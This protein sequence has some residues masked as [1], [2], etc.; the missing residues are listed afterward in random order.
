MGCAC[1]TAAGS[2]EQRPPTRRYTVQAVAAEELPEDPLHRDLPDTEPLPFSP[3]TAALHDEF[4]H[5]SF[6]SAEGRAVPEPPAAIVALRVKAVVSAAGELPEEVAPSPKALRRAASKSS[7]KVL[8]WLPTLS[9]EGSFPNAAVGTSAHSGYMRQRNSDAY[10][11]MSD[12]G[13]VA[14][15]RAGSE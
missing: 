1:S 7:A 3:N 6:M 9:S 10:G 11:T 8:E 5:A 13:S 2:D 14:T 12:V 4:D 15:S